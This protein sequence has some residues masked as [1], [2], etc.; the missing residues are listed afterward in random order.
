M[1]KLDTYIVIEVN[2]NGN[3]VDSFT[4]D[5]EGLV[6]AKTL[7]EERVRTMVEDD[8]LTEERIQSIL[9]AEIFE[10]GYGE[11]IQLTT[12]TKIF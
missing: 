8:E 2:E 12:T 1:A 11:Y 5:T 3:S 6:E 10:I 7:F 4:H 9:Q